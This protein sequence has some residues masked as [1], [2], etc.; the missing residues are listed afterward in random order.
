MTHVA[1]GRSR[2]LNLIY[3]TGVVAG[4]GVG[5]VGGLVNLLKSNGRAAVH[6]QYHARYKFCRL[7]AKINRRPAN[8]IRLAEFIQRCAAENFG[9]AGRVTTQGLIEHVRSYPARR[10][11]VDAHA[12]RAPLVRQATHH[13]DVGRFCGGIRDD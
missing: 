1:E 4:A 6:R 7:A 11:G 9:F 3:M 8:V 5:S 12:V 2:G 13:A 10:N